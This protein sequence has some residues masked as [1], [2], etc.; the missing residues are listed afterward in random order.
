MCRG[1]V[2]LSLGSNVGAR[3]EQLLE[4]VSRLDEEPRV[5]LK[6]LS[7]LYETEPV[8][9]RT[10]SL[11]VNAVVEIEFDGTPRLLLDLCRSLEERAGRKG[12]GS[13]RPLDI[14]I[15]LFDDMA[16]REPDLVIPH[17]R[18]RE[19]L[20][21][22]APM[23]EIAPDVLLPPDERTAGELIRSGNPK[24]WIRRISGRSLHRSG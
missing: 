17:P 9:V 7:P 21:V 11:F 10:T 12:P 1:D 15:I 19:R 22:L 24:G 23:A 5:T 18:F 20:F 4:A 3:E 13:D 16:L 2:F 6:R 8:D 14:D